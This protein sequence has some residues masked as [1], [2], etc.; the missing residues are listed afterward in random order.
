[1]E[2]LQVIQHPA[3]DAL[4]V[5]RKV[6][7]GLVFEAEDPGLRHRVVDWRVVGFESCRAVVVS[8]ERVFSA[9]SLGASETVIV[10]RDQVG[11]K[12]VSTMP[13]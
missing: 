8:R 9:G 5:K 11:G 4:L 6:P 1:V 2:G 12:L 10:L 3:L 13:G 7:E